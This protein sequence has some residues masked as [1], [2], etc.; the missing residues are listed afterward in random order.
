M[1]TAHPT[2][3]NDCPQRETTTGHH[4]NTPTMR[5]QDDDDTLHRDTSVRRDI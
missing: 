5:H 2:T 4:D 3:T 1:T